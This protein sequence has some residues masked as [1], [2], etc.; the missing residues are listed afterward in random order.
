MGQALSATG[1][2][3]R[4]RSNRQHWFGFTPY[5]TAI[6][7]NVT[8]PLQLGIMYVLFNYLVILAWT[9]T[10]NKEKGLP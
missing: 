2:S 5:L 7:Q 6:M 1:G 9:Y 8:I 3:A 4:Y 10:T